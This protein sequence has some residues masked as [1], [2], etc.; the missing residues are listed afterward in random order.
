MMLCV[1]NLCFDYIH[2]ENE[3]GLSLSGHLFQLH[4]FAQENDN[5]QQ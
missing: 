5:A 2:K 1:F 4:I 3:G